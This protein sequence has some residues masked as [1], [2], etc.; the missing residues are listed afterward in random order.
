MLRPKIVVVTFVSGSKG[1]VG[2]STLVANLAML[3]DVD[4]AIVDLGIDGNMSS[5]IMHG[6]SNDDVGF[7]DYVLLGCEYRVL[8][9]KF[10]GRVYIIPPGKIRGF[11][12][13][14]L[15]ISNR[16]VIGGRVERFIRELQD[17]GIEV[18]LIDTPANV[19]LLNILYIAL[20]Y[21]SDIINIVVEPSPLCIETVQS[22][23]DSFSKIICRKSQIVNMIVNKYL[24]HYDEITSYL[25]KFT[26]NGVIHKI[27]F[28]AYTLAISN[29]CELA[30][31]YRESD[32]FTKSLKTL[33]KI[34]TAQISHCLGIPRGGVR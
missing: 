7:L 28:D 17:Q 2:K 10:S 29:K 26:I 14:I 11:R 21:H 22:W 8:R 27:P 32:K 31:R 30:V 19:E 18:V 3:F 20:L 15:S 13:T 5:S 1:G 34:L 23:W 9:S 6:V 16:D 33:Y 12:A 24:K 4:V 25:S